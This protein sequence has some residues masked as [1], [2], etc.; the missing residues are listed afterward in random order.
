M[1]GVRPATRPTIGIIAG[2]GPDAG[3]DLWSKI[4]SE[5]RTRLGDSYRGDIDAPRVVVVSEPALGAS[6]N[7]PASDPEVWTALLASAQEIASQCDTYAIACNTLNIYADRLRTE[8]PNAQIISYADVAA[9]WIE[10]A[11]IDTVGLL[12]AKPVTELGEWSPY[13]LLT[14]IVE[15][16][17]PDNPDA[18]HALIE[19]IKL[20]GGADPTHAQQLDSLASSLNVDATLL[21]CTELPLVMPGASDNEYI[22]VTTLVAKALVDHVAGQ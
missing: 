13:S 22:D 3:I 12:A 18:V 20:D 2:S 9:E 15:V 17:T 1:V 4:L 10:E 14:R 8:V 11:G 5:T 6:M 16:R 19:S 7:L 21:A